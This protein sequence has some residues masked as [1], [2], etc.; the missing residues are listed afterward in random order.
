MSVWRIDK[1]DAQTRALAEAA[2]KAA[3]MPLGAW[4]ER[5]IMRRVENR[6]V[7]PQPVFAPAAIDEPA[8]VPEPQPDI[9][10][11]MK[12]AL[13]AAERRRRQRGEKIDP[14][15][16]A[17]AELSDPF[18]APE[19]E[20]LEAP[21]EQSENLVVPAEADAQPSIKL[22]EEELIALDEDREESSAAPI[23]DAEELADISPASP[24]AELVQDDEPIP[25]ILSSIVDRPQDH[26]SGVTTTARQSVLPHQHGASVKRRIPSSLPFIVVGLI[27]ALAA[28]GGAYVFLLPPASDTPQAAAPAA[29]TPKPIEQA[30]AS[31]VEP[32]MPP[33]APAPSAPVVSP[34]STASA[35]TT[36][37]QAQEQAPP[38]TSPPAPLPR[39]AGPS[40]A[41]IP[42]TEPAAAEPTRSAPIAMPSAAMPQAEAPP[43]A[44]PSETLPALRARAEAGDVAAQVELGS[45]YIDGRGVGRNEVEA[46]K[47]LL[48]A[49]DQGHAQA[50]F[51]IGVMYERGVGLAASL[52]KAIEYYRKAGAQNTPMALHN[53]ALIHTMEQP[54]LKPDFIQARRLMTQAA[55][56]GLPESQY[57]L[58]LMHLQGVGGPVDRV[59][60]LSWMG[61]AARPSMPKLVDAV[62]Q[63]AAQYNEAD[64]QRAQQLMEGHLRRIQAN[65]QKLQSPASAP[66]IATA[67]VTDPPQAKPRVIDRAA[68]M[69]MQKM[70]AGLKIYGG[71]ADGTMGPRTAAAI[72]EFQAMAGMPVDGKPSAELLDNLREVAGL[73]KQ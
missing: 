8:P 57:S 1:I 7:T 45:R 43:A 62:R 11:E 40:I 20:S 24:P 58:A 67:A 51:N 70:L 25:D 69:E 41:N 3:G 49:A 29:P 31:K 23:F 2:A 28:A 9:S 35:T 50:Q 65:Q 71:T 10:A 30:T 17:A 42:V 37:A 19:P 48:R 59:L 56:L 60:A 66:S 32:A 54:G 46:S 33:P 22:E 38:T 13:E 18:A 73:T 63:L 36:P 26:A 14:P 61:V 16:G 72:K 34:P 52:P 55:E 64:R 5:A 27:I 68:I 39:P 21:F 47:W 12:S 4:L 6:T 44:A 53:L 15:T